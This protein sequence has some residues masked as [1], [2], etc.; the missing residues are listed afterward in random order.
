MRSPNL[1]ALGL[2]V[3]LGLIVS[4]SPSYAGNRPS[5]T[6]LFQ[7]LNGEVSRELNGTGGSFPLADGGGLSVVTYDAGV[8]C[9]AVATGA[10]YEA[11][12]SAAGHFCPW[13]DGGCSS[14]IGS[15]NFGKPV[16][17]STATAPAPFWFVT[18]ASTTSTKLVCVT[19]SASASMVCALFRM[20]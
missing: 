4:V 3:V 16:N 14:A 20:R 10:V 11:H 9:Q 13:G 12:C 5:E 7:M 2:G 15:Q 6:P 8:G 18:E 1:L 17:A 19:P